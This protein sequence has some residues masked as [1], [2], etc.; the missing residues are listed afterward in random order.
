MI[1]CSVGCPDESDC[2]LLEEGIC[3]EDFSHDVAERVSIQDYPGVHEEVWE[4]G[5]KEQEED[6]SLTQPPFTISVTDRFSLL[7]DECI[8]L[9]LGD[10]DLPEADV[11]KFKT[12][13]FQAKQKQGS[14]DSEFLEEAIA[15]AAEQR[16]GLSDTT[17]VALSNY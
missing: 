1:G 12:S 2:C 10:S 9:D 11:E 13:R 15:I 14:N 3:F 8:P 16:V 4:D 6:T 5:C 17:D 7:V